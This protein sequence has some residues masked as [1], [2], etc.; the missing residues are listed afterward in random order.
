MARYFDYIERLI[1]NRTTLT[2]EGLAESV[3]N[4]LEFNKYQVL[5]GKETI[6]HKNAEQKASAEYDEFN[7]YQ[8]IESDFDK[9]IKRLIDKKAN[10]K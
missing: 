2:M 1:E 5:E 7:K 8:K 3:N 9:T 10:D 6:S 4:F